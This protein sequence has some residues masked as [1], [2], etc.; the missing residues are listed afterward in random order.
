MID[1]VGSW[2][3]SGSYAGIFIGVALTGLGL[4]VPEEAFV[5]FAG[6]AS[7]HGVLKT[8]WLAA[9]SC[10]SGALIGDFITY[11]LGRHFGHSVLREHPTISKHLTPA[12]EKHIEE[13][14]ERH[15]FKVFL[16][17]RFLVGLRSPVYLTAGIL[18]VPLWR[19]LL[20]DAISATIVIGC[21]FSLSYCFADQIQ[22]W[23]NWIRQ[24]ELALSVI[25]VVA[26]G[27]AVLVLYRKYR[28]TMEREPEALLD[29]ALGCTKCT[30]DEPL[31]TAPTD[32]S[33][34]DDQAANQ[35]P[36]LVS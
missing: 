23:W 8:P 15:G 36:T 16:V 17:S 13:L 24:A 31:A 12:R 2:F 20:Y 30:D 14:I 27:I 4:P 25:V 33:S 1:E 35:P 22:T 3:E 19:F 10:L 9:L 28:K 11:S 6:M 26:V 32:N 7:A 18:K 29:Q 21:F 5:L 34:N